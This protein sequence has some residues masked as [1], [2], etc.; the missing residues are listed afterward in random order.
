MPPPPHNESLTKQ[1]IN[2]KK[3]R[4]E[5]ARRHS[6]LRLELFKKIEKILSLAKRNCSFSPL[7]GEKKFLSELCELRNFREG[8]NLKRSSWNSNS[9]RRLYF[10]KNIN[11]DSDMLHHDKNYKGRLGILAQRE[12]GFE[13]SLLSGEGSDSV[14]SSDFKS[15]I[16]IT[17][18]NNLSCKDFS[19]FGRSALLC[20][21]GKDLSALVPQYLSNFSDTVF[22]R[23]TSHFSRK[24]VAFTLAEVLITLGIIG[25]IAALTLPSLIVNYQKKQTVQQLKTAYSLL[26]QAVEQSI[27]ENGEIDDWD[28]TLNTSAFNETYILP[29]LKIVKKCDG[30][31][32]IKT[33]NFNGYYEL[34][35]NKYTRIS[36]SYVLANGMI[37]MADYPERG[38]LVY[39]IDL[40]GNKKPNIMGKDIFAFYLLN[41]QSPNSAEYRNGL[42]NIQ[43]NLYIGSLGN[44][45]FPHY[46]TDRTSLTKS[47]IHRSCNKNSPYGGAHGGIGS[48]CAAVIM[49]DGW[50][51][52]KDYPW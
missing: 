8:Y 29:Y 36:G 50:K 22:S 35:G 9:D 44:N 38:F 1:F 14:I 33:D 25:I 51:I 39:M 49:K 18:E 48:A 47:Q 4:G 17:N 10:L 6:L 13:P 46:Q 23:F 24:R 20:R 32:C 37:L 52:S 41:H 12:A 16:S 28:Y 40:N 19:Y 7:E 2:K 30:G 5:D 27:S 3:L 34:T 43:A 11:Y 31:K 15:K 21:Q 26:S 45:G 42:K